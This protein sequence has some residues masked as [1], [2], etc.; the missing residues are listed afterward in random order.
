FS[1]EIRKDVLKL[2]LIGRD[3]AC[4]D[5]AFPLPDGGDLLHEADIGV[6][7]D[8]DRVDFVPVGGGIHCGFEGVGAGLGLVGRGAAVAVPGDVCAAVGEQEEDFGGA[9]ARVRGVF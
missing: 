2:G 9:S 8:A 6:G 7:P 3:I 4:G 5:I 1:A